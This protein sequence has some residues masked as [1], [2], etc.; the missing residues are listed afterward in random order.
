M[1]KTLPS[2]GK[3][4]PQPAGRS[5]ATLDRLASF[6]VTY[7]AIFCFLLLYVFSVKG[8]ELA[9]GRYFRARI[10]EA[11]QVDPQAGSVVDQIQ[12]RVDAVV[13]G[14]A[15]AHIGGVRV[16]AIVLGADGTTPL[17]AGG[18]RIPPPL[19]EDP[20]AEAQRLL[21][22]SAEVVVSV[23]H[24]SLVANAVLVFYAALLIQTLF[25]YERRRARDEDTRLAQ[26]LAERESTAA[27][28]AQIEAEL[29]DLTRQVDERVEAE[30]SGELA[31]LQAERAQLSEKLTALARREEELR[32]QT[33]QLQQTLASERAGLEEMLDEAL[34]DLSRKD[35]SLRAL[36]EKLQR[37]AQGKGEAAGPR[38][39]EIDLLGLRLRT[40]YKNLEI[41]DHALRDLIALGDEAMKLRAEESLKRLSD[42]VETA[43]VRRKVGG[44][45]SHLTVFELGFAGKGR[46]YY[47]I[48]RQRRFRLLA[49]GAKNSQK[50]DLEYLSR[51]PRE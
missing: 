20:L 24:N 43:A 38:S 17:Y 21:P 1:G 22:A 13:R 34:A 28:A 25:L 31:S 49:V 9:L 47:T 33:G 14:S 6:R 29:A 50:T 45:P 16:T 36:E 4:L 37:A 35:E 42:D 12:A 51:L 39:R 2:E 41:D 27:R 18:R 48:G 46:I 19:P 26:A 10:A 40:L 32:A 3:R 7:V 44:L 30:V 23:P 5:T 15:W 8:I 11:V